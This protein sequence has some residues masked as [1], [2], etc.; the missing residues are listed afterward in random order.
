M[1]P[2]TLVAALLL[3]GTLAALAPVATA[4]PCCYPPPPPPP[5][6]PA[7][8]SIGLDPLYVEGSDTCQQTVVIEPVPG[9]ASPTWHK[10]VQQGKATVWVGTC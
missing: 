4:Q 3:L 9:C 8:Q 6:C 1:T 7:Y 5:R 10:V 2:K